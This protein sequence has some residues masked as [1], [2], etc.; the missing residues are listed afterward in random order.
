M[1]IL[2]RLPAPLRDPGTFSIDDIVRLMES[3]DVIDLALG[4][5]NEAL[6]PPVR[7]AGIKAMRGGYDQY[8]DSRACDLC[9]RRSPI[10]SVNKEASRS[11]PRPKLLLPPGRRKR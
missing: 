7:Y 2:S 1:K 5:S 11:I 9:V 8:E 3:R 4:S 10:I 6:A